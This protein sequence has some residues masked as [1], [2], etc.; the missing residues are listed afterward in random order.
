MV[1]VVREALALYGHTVNVELMTWQRG[2]QFARDGQMHGVIGTDEWET[3]DLLLSGPVAV[4]R[5]VTA[6]RPGE[7]VPYDCDRRSNTRPR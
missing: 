2:I 1:D 4:Y 6:F 7:A 5:E 3:P